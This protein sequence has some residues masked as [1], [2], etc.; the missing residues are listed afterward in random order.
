VKYCVVLEER[1]SEEDGGRLIN[2]L[3]LASYPDEER[4][5]RRANRENRGVG[6]LTSRIT[7]RVLEER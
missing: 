5:R 3:W 2:R 4:A 1:E 6:S 7:A